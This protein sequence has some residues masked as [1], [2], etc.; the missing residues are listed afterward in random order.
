MM[1][2]M[3]KCGHDKDCHGFHGDVAINDDGSKTPF[4]DCSF[5]ACREFTIKDKICKCKHTESVHLEGVCT[6][7]TGKH[8]VYYCPCVKFEGVK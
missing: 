1:M 8:K 5:C 4:Y 6:M 3:C 2:I 7:T